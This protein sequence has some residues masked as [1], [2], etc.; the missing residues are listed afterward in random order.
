[1]LNANSTSAR[2]VRAVRGA[3]KNIR[4]LAVVDSGEDDFSRRDFNQ[5]LFSRVF[6]APSACRDNALVEV[7]FTSP[8][9]Q[10]RVG[11][12]LRVD[13]EQ[14]KLTH[15]G[16]YIIC[17]GDEWIGVRQLD[18]TGDGWRMYDDGPGK[19]PRLLTDEEVAGFQVVGIVKDVYKKAI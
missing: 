11:D 8:P 4:S 19:E 6:G 1:M 9:A 14:R 15:E 17:I 3:T 7:K 10:L 13:F 5:S 18:V 2:T 16:L 12:L